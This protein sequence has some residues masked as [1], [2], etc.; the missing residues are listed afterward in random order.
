MSWAGNKLGPN[1]I[2]FRTAGLLP[3]LALVPLLAIAQEPPPAT[4]AS[5]A[6]V[7]AVEEFRIQTANLSSSSS[8]SGVSQQRTAPKAA[9]HGNLYENIRND[10]LDANPHEIVQRGGDPRKLR[11]NQ[12]G[13]N[14]TGPVKI[15]KIYNG[16]GSTFFT[17]Q[18]EGMRQSIG[19]FRL[20]T[21]PTALERTGSFEKTVDAAGNPL[22]IYDPQTT[23]AN[24]AYNPTLPVSTT[25][26]QYLRQQFPGNTIP[27]VRLDRVALSALQFYPEPN[28]AAGPFFQNNFYSVT[29][30]VDSANGFNTTID[31]SFLQKHRL[32]VKLGRSLGVNGNA[33]I[34]LTIANPNGPSTDVTSRSLRVEHVYT[35]SAAN[36]NTLSFEASSRT[37]QNQA[38]VDAAGKVFPRY[39]ISGYLGMGTGNPV[40]REARNDFRVNDTFATRW[41]AHRFSVSVDLD[42][43]QVNVFRPT[44]P[45]GSFQFTAGLTSLPGI[46]NTGH[47]FASFLLGQASNASQS[48]L[49]SPSYWRWSTQR[50]GFNDQWQLSPSLTLNI[51]VNVEHLTQRVDKYDRQSNISF[52]EINPENGRPGALVAANRGGYGRAFTPNWLDA[53]PNIGLAW[54]VLGNNNTVLRLNYHRGYYSPQTNGNQFGTQAF[55]GTPVWLSENQQ[56]TPAVVLADGLPRTAFPNLRLDAANGTVAD[57]LDTSH[58]QPMNQNVGGSLQRQLAKNLILT[59]SF[60]RSYGKDQPVGRGTVNPNA[61][62]LSALA[63][64]DKLNDLQFSRSLRPYPQYQDF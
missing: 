35:A 42:Q 24:P 30:Q 43:F 37:N 48:V 41:R 60:N 7:R 39:D 34:F 20:N 33:P 64:R 54:S 12:W 44:Y 28:T 49:S 29:P 47:G 5:A 53:E 19:Q 46:I 62:P 18:Y 13:L 40:A 26:L 2:V 11:R 50:Y 21:I 58:R 25:N 56:L 32:T 9:F 36:I 1:G 14:L 51:G 52:T 16:A 59:V 22:Q 3:A 15:P 61:I 55:N 6:L 8:E 45:E 10:F 38:P 63:Y 57:L 23:S 17:F 27:L 4:P 31:H